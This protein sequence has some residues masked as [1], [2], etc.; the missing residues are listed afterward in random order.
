MD[1]ELGG[2]I[3]ANEKVMGGAPRKSIAWGF[4]IIS[5]WNG[6]FRGAT[7][8]WNG[9]CYKQMKRVTGGAKS[10]WTGS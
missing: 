2:A 5:K 4:A 1:W 6:N 10:K 7:S 3:Q 9:R 8:K